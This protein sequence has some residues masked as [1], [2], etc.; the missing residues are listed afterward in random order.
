MMP[1]QTPHILSLLLYR[2]NQHGATVEE[3]AMAFE[4]PLW[5]I[6]ERIEAVRLCL[7]KQVR[8]Q[9]VPRRRRRVAR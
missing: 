2:E 6:Q 4:L 1:T 9:V 8:V 5:W 7:E 3:L